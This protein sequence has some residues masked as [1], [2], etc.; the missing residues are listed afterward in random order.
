MCVLWLCMR[1]PRW[2]GM[3]DIWVSKFWDILSV[4]LNL[5]KKKTLNFPKVCVCAQTPPTTHIPPDSQQ[6]T[7]CDESLYIIQELHRLSD[8][9]RFG[10]PL[11]LILLFIEISTGP[12]HV[13]NTRNY[14]L[15]CVGFE[16]M[17]TKQCQTISCT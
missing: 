17:H 7:A 14:R 5:K 13:I 10:L 4:I 2:K 11:S 16:N 3:M 12:F 6:I 15:L 1:H 8:L 9:C